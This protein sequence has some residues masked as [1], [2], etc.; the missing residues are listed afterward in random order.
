MRTLWNELKIK[1]LHSGSRVSLLIGINLIVF[2]LINIPAIFETLFWRHETSLIGYYADE[3]LA[4]PSNFTKLLY[5]FWTPVTYMFMHAGILH[6]VFNML[7]LF[8]IGQIFEEYLGTKRTIG[9]YLL[10][11]LTGALFFVLGFNFIPFFAQQ[12]GDASVPIVGASAAVMAILVA[13]ATLLPDYTM[14]LMLFG[15]V[16]L[17]WLAITFVI[18]DFLMV[19]GSNA[20]G[21]L[22]HLGGA[23]FGFIYIKQLQRGNDWVGF[24]TKMFSKKPNLKVVA[25]NN[26]R[27]G[28]NVPRQEDID[29]ILDKISQSG[30]DS[31]TRQEK[32]ILF[33]ASKDNEG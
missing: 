11:G 16:K 9:L 18:L 3:Y 20:G 21:E 25:K 24:F 14:V 12:I 27:G 5:R 30:Y 32:E 26:S 23:L 15:P 4:L 10:G 8:W 7:W 22:S 6:I 13:T 31:L 2:L 17:K 1:M 28:G 19:A 29:R 33:R